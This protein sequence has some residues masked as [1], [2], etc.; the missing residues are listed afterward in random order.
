MINL[1]KM[2]QMGSIA[3]K[4]HPHSL[5]FWY[6]PLNGRGR[7][8]VTSDHEKPGSSHREELHRWMSSINMSR[9]KKHTKHWPRNPI[10]LSLVF[11]ELRGLAMVR[12]PHFN[13]YTSLF[14]EST[15]QLSQT[16]DAGPT[17]A[18]FT[19]GPPPP[20]SLCHHVSKTSRHS[21]AIW[22]FTASWNHF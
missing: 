22:N 4:S 16:S 3:M 5:V 19:L 9:Q 21:R 12:T 13:S 7:C 18:P 11:K 1:F 2:N 14:M 20:Y 8:G 17:K 6:A 10:S 15:L